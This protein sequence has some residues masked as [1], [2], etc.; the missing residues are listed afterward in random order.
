MGKQFTPGPSRPPSAPHNRS[1]LETNTAD[2]SL[3]AAGLYSAFLKPCAGP[4]SGHL[5]AKEDPL[6]NC[7]FAVPR[8]FNVKHASA[9]ATARQTL[10]A[11]RRHVT[12]GCHA[13]S[14]ERRWRARW[15]HFGRASHPRR[16]RVEF[17]QRFEVVA[18]AGLKFPHERTCNGCVRRADFDP[19]LTLVLP[20]RCA[21]LCLHPSERTVALSVGDQG[22]LPAPTPPSS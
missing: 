4:I 21:A 20:L 6:R 10:G 17:S 15:C 5:G 16:P 7:A 1:S 3:A 14:T 2:M 8:T 13:R 22:S 19:S 9:T 11:T 12:S 18:R